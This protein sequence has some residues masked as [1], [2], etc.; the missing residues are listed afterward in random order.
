MNAKH[1]HKFSIKKQVLTL[2]LIARLIVLLYFFGCPANF[3]ALSPNYEFCAVI[4]GYLILQYVVLMVQETKLGPRF[5]VPK[6]LRPKIY[7]YYRGLEEEKSIDENTDCII[8]MTPL[9]LQGKISE[10]TVNRSK[11]MH[12]PCNHKFH[13]DCLMNWMAIKME[14]PTCRKALPLIEE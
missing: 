7:S 2:I 8:C 10:E 4:C 13:E 14:C 3:L 12:A 1:G 11:T 9:N 6:I 5:L